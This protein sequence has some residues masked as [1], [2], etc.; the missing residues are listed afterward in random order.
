MEAVEIA[1]YK[2]G[3]GN[4]VAVAEVVEDRINQIKSTLPDGM[5][6]EKVYDNPF[7]FLLL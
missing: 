3:D 7:S 5:K 4:T 1:I 2:E 6:L